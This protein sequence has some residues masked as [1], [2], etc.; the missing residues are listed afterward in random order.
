MAIEFENGDGVF[1]VVFNDLDEYIEIV[2]DIIEEF[3]C[4]DVIWFRVI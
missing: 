2:G 3:W 4:G 1:L